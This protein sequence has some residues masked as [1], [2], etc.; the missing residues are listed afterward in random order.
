MIETVEILELEEVPSKPANTSLSVPDSSPAGMMLSALQQG[1]NPDQIER[2]MAL[3]ERWDATEARK[4]YNVA[5][6]AF[7]AE[8]V[9][10]VKNRRVENGPLAGK[11]YAELHAVVDALTPALSQHGLS[12]SWKLT[13]DEKDWMEVT[14]YLRH[15]AGHEE[16]ASMGGPPDA[17]GAK[18]AI[19]ARASTKSYL[20]RYTLKA[21]CG[22]AEGGDDND[23]AGGAPDA[24]RALWVGRAN[25]ATTVEE[26][27]RVSKDG[28]KAFNDA[29]DPDGYRIFAEAVQVNGA[30]LRANKK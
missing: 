4:A 8:A 9:H 14:C 16:S 29:K 30:A 2:M 25:L 20:E 3:Q 28:A 1:A 12:A 10:I 5:F 19:Q 11:S 6:A 7:K 15:S 24:L 17:G 23:G 21:I 27:T 13:K 18:N 26:M 22:V